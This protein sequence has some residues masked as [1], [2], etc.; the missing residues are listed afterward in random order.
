[1]PELWTLRYD[2]W[3]LPL[4]VTPGDNGMMLALPALPLLPKQTKAVEYVLDKIAFS[5]LEEGW[6]VELRML[7][8]YAQ[9]SP[10]VDPEDCVR[11]LPPRFKEETRLEFR[12]MEGFFE[13]IASAGWFK[14]PK[15]AELIFAVFCRHMMHWLTYRKRKVD[16]GFC[17]LVPLPFRANWKELILSWQMRPK[18]G[19]AGV[20]W[21]KQSFKEYLLRCN[22]LLGVRAVACR[23]KKM[24][25]I[26][27]SLECVAQSWWHKVTADME[28]M[29]SRRVSKKH[30]TRLYWLEVS[31][32]MREAEED[33]RAAYFSYLTQAGAPTV[34]MVENLFT[35]NLVPDP[36]QSKTYYI[37]C[38]FPLGNHYQIIRGSGKNLNEHAGITIDFGATPA[39][40]RPMYDFQPGSPDLRDTRDEGSTGPADGVSVSDGTQ[41]PSSG[42]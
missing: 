18:K 27:W 5:H 12:D 32:K 25:G 3:T 11:W 29:R 20:N 14:S 38:P 4:H 15:A 26:V 23:S 8:Q 31:R 16:L 17:R 21:L 37:D 13:S 19:R 24:G 1:M 34:Q 2:H 6:Y 42:G 10:G 7:V 22:G 9:P 36:Q 35:H 30:S 33:A 28:G 41:S 40:L 39:A